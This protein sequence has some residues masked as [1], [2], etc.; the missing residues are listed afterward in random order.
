MAL[1]TFT[2]TSKFMNSELA[3]SVLPSLHIT[4]VRIDVGTTN[5]DIESHPDDAVFLDIVLEN[6]SDR[7]EYQGYKKVETV[8]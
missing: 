5:I 6:M 3:L 4:A 8:N 7:T 2:G 1:F